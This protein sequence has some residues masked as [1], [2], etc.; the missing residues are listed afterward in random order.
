VIPA[1][2]QRDLA[3]LIPGATIHEAACGHAG[4]VLEHQAFVPALL[5]AAHTTSARMGRRTTTR[6][7]S[8]VN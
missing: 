4:C 3:A 2:R 1:D 5:E 8:L 7:Q 6:D